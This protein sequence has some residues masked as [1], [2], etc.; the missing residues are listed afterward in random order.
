M[1][2]NGKKKKQC[3]YVYY[4]YYILYVAWANS[5]KIYYIIII[6]IIYIIIIVYGL[7]INDRGYSERR[8]ETAA[9]TRPGLTGR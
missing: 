2:V 6:I 9:G 1:H 5:D 4:I 8:A 3:V 7:M